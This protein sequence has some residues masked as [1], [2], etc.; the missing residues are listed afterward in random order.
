M[1]DAEQEVES[2][3]FL[4]NKETNFLSSLNRNEALLDY[5]QCIQE[6]LNSLFTSAKI[7]QGDK[8]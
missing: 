1:F 7:C 3:D 8:F 4:S 5:F 6:S 2:Q